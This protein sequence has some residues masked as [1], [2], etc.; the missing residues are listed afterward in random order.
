VAGVV[1]AQ[2]Q[3][4]PV[5]LVLAWD[6]ACLVFLAVTWP[7]IVRANGAAT[8]ALSERED[9]GRLVARAVLL[10]ASVASLAGVGAILSIAGREGGG[11]EIVLITT[12]VAT[13]VLSWTVINTVYTLRYARLRYEQGPI[14]IGFPD[15]TTEDQPRYLDFAYVAF[16]IGMT[17]QVSDTSVRDRTTRT[18]VLCHSL[19][20]YLFGVVIVAGMINLVAGLVR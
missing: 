19:L 20:S 15:Q 1:A 12:A 11:E 7:V 8:K 9:P 10:G 3:P 6:A 18:A 16:T 13:V 5:S 14:G 17:Y 2:F 4:W